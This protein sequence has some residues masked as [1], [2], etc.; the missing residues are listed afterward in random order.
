MEGAYRLF[1]AP[2]NAETIR[3]AAE[4]RFSRMTAAYILI[5]RKRKP[6]ALPCV[7]V[8]GDDLNRLTERDRAWLR[9]SIL[10]ILTE[11]AAKSRNETQA[12]MNALMDNLEAALREEQEKLRREDGDDESDG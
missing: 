10:V 8:R 9:D 3:L 4:E 1:A 12:R 11:A 7:E 6:R 2:V 5:Y